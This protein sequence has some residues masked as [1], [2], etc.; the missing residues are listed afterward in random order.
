VNGESTF[1]ELP[2]YVSALATE[3]TVQITPI[4]HGKVRTLNAS[5]VENNQFTV[6]GEN[7]PFHWLVHGKRG[8]IDQIEPYKKDVDVKGLGPYKWI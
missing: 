3:L 8:D 6:Y 1:I 4:Y 5:E 7:G 2:S